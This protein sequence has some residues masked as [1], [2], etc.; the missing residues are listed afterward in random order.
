MSGNGVYFRWIDNFNKMYAVQT[1]NIKRGAYH[2]MMWMGSGVR[3]PHAI[4]VGLV[5]RRVEEGK[6]GMPD[7]LFLAPALEYFKR[8]SSTQ[9]ER[10]KIKTY[11]GS[12]CERY[13]VNNI[14]LKPV[15][16]DTHPLEIRETLARSPDGL[17]HFYPE[18]VHD[19]NIGANEGLAREFRR[20]HNE[21][22]AE[23]PAQADYRFMVAD[24]NI[25]FRG[26]KVCSAQGKFYFKYCRVYE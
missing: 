23:E 19:V 8:A 12:L 11:A 14:P 9:T 3:V 13:N 5:D 17:A 16:D 2:S 10:N 18:G 6:P 25:F 7:D 4:P 26:I 22:V 15:L 24:V 20:L 21:I 1:P